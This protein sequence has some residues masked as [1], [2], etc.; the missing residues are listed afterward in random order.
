[1]WPPPANDQERV[2]DL[3][4]QRRDIGLPRHHRVDPALL[5]GRRQAELRPDVLDGQVLVFHAGAAQHHLEIFV[6]RLPARES[7]ALA[8]QVG[9]LAGID[10][11]ALT[12]DDGERLIGVVAGRIVHDDADHFERLAAMTRFQERGHAHVA[13]LHLALLHGVDHFGAGA[14]DL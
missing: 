13:D 7:D 14:H 12:R 8:L 10:A 9:D 11:G 4:E 1:M 6:G 5:Q 2:G 3:I